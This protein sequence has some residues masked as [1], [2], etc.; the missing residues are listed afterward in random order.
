MALLE[1]QVI[2]KRKDKSGNTYME[3]PVTRVGYVEG[4]VAS[5]NGK[6]PDDNQNI[7]LNT[8]DTKSTNP[9]TAVSNDTVAKWIELGAGEYFFN[10]SYL[11]D[12]PTTS[13]FLCNRVTD[14]HVF[15]WFKSQPNGNLYYRDG[16]TTNGWTS[17]WVEL[18]V[19]Q[20]TLP[21]ASASTLGGVKI[22]SNITNSSGVISLSK[23]NVTS[24]LGYTPV[25]SVNG[26]MADDSGNVDIIAYN[27]MNFSGTTLT[28]K[29]T[30]GG[31]TSYDL[32]NTFAKKSEVV[33]SVNG[34]T[35]EVTVDR[36]PVGTVI[37]VAANSAPSGY[38]LCNG[39]AVSRTTYAGLFAKI[40]TTYGTGDGST[41]FNLPN[42][43]DKFIQGSGTAGSVKSAGLPN[44]TGSYVSISD[45]RKYTVSGALY[46][47]DS[48][49]YR[50]NT[51]GAYDGYG[52]GFDASK[53][54][55]IYG[56]STTVQP[57]ALTM[58]MYIKY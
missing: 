12:Q 24:A 40:G 20:Y 5:V 51:A 36:V 41:T 17:S 16:N 8:L 22:G 56:N 57:P 31:S 47:G 35:G 25:K 14:T 48:G 32:G 46:K 52:I 11:N 55:S 23:S 10:A 29:K 18:L 4:A 2:F 19:E 38:L 28:M 33:T 58:R 7:Q 27:D 50:Y 9:I 21:T 54:N 45:S 42:L 53:S 1:R 15:Q 34:V 13:G 6:L 30:N 49:A 39:A 26:T 37:A 3:F 43:T 44:I